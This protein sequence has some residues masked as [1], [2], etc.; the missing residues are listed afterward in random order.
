MIRALAVLAERLGRCSGSVVESNYNEWV[1]R[2]DLKR[3]IAEK[4]SGIQELRRLDRRSHGA[5]VKLML[6]DVEIMDFILEMEEGKEEVERLRAFVVQ[7]MKF[8][9]RQLEVRNLSPQTI[10]GFIDSWSDRVDGSS[11]YRKRVH[12]ISPFIRYISMDI[13]DNLGREG[14][15]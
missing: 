14:L 13:E 12:S 5:M 3:Q 6:I 7:R 9:E 11:I 8:S 2:Q 4:G 15:D 10:S 1:I